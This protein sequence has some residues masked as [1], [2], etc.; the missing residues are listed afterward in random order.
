MWLLFFVPNT[1]FNVQQSVLAISKIL[2]Q[3][4]KKGLADL[5]DAPDVN[6]KETFMLSVNFQLLTSVYMY[7]ILHFYLQSHEKVN[8]LACNF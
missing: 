5:H 6:R 8:V 4:N 1:Y 2:I 7:Y 3:A